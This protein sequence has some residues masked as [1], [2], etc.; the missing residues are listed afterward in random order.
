M[1]R[2]SRRCSLSWSVITDLIVRISTT[3]WSSSQSTRE[4]HSMQKQATQ[5]ASEGYTG[6]LTPRF[7]LRVGGL[8][9]N[10]IDDLRFDQTAQWHET[11]LSLENLLIRQKSHLVDIL[12]DAVGIHKENQ[13]LRRKLL[14]LKRDVFNLRVSSLEEARTLEQA[15]GE[16]ERPFLHEWLDLWERYQ[17]RLALGSEILKGELLRKRN[18][19]KELVTTADF[20]KGVLLSSPILDQAIDGSLP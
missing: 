4:E 14:R 16:N 5:S 20:R 6:V 7:L 10:A 18:R 2:T 12:H 1:G 13:A 11:I 9:I 8:P 3:G 19:L 17:Q 15:L